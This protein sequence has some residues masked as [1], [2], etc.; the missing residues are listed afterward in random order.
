MKQ[1]KVHIKK[2]FTKV[3]CNKK[4]LGDMILDFLD[5][6]R[7]LVLLDLLIAMSQ[8]NKLT[9]S[10]IMD[11]VNTFIIGVTISNGFLNFD[12]HSIWICII[13]KYSIEYII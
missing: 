5:K 3:I 13:L 9:D 8:E 7:R 4:K 1:L 10:D 12:I 6:R 11:E 2:N